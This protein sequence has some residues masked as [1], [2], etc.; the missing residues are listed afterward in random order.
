MDP[1]FSQP[2]L[3][4]QR[5]VDREKLVIARVTRLVRAFQL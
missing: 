2:E 4:A 1:D 3:S 5:R